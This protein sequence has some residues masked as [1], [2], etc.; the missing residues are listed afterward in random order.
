M[1]W[2]IKVEDHDLV[3]PAD[4]VFQRFGS[5][6]HAERIA[7]KMMSQNGKRYDVYEHLDDGARLVSDSVS[8][9]EKRVQQEQGAV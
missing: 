4:Y 5:L 8:A 3:F 6:S 9:L 2:T 1:Y 7:M